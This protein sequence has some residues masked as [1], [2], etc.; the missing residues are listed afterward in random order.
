MKEDIKRIKKI[1]D[2]FEMKKKNGWGGSRAGAGRKAKN[3]ATLN[4]YISPELLEKIKEEAKREK[5][6]TGEVVERR[7]KF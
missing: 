7:M 4:C 3:N 2:E 5:I 6:S 1:F